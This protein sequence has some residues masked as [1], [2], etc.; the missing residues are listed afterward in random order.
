MEEIKQRFQRLRQRVMLAIKARLAED[1]YCK[2]Y[3]GTFEWFVSFPSYFEDGE[4]TK[5]PDSYCLLLHCYVL[6]PAR[7]YK[8]YGATPEEALNRA[9]KEIETWLTNG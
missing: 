5:G 4:G 1:P 7:H 8:W 6:G 9:E 2:S 3:E